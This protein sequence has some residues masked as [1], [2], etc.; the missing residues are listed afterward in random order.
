LARI[1]ELMPDR[2]SAI[3]SELLLKEENPKILQYVYENIPQHDAQSLV[4]RVN[5][6]AFLHPGAFSW[7]AQTATT[8]G[9]IFESMLDG[10]FLINVLTAIDEPEFSAHRTRMKKALES[11]LL[12]NILKKGIPGDLAQKAIE[13]LDHSDNIEEYRRERWKGTIRVHVPQTKERIDWI[14]ST[15]EAFERKRIELE[16]L[17]TVELPKNRKAVG[18]AAAHGDLKEN[19]EYKAARERQDYLINRV[20]QMQDELRRVRVLDPAQIDSSEVRPGTRVVLSQSPEKQM[21]VTILGP[22]E[23]NPQ[24]GI[25]SFEAP[26]SK[27]LIGKTRGERIEWLGET[28]II[29]SIDP[30]ISA[31]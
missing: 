20:Q 29:E 25:Y 1:R 6:H 15:K 26:F 24:E 4:E 5:S 22:W 28:W 12:M 9:S 18:E 27:N 19:F 14:F 21:T 31:S 7:I 3:F 17:I 16:Q 10:K 2:W 30:W 8:E 23:S 13:R 11:G